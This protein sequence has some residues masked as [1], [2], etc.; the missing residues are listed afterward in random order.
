MV[1]GLILYLGEGTDFFVV[2]VD[3]A[4]YQARFAAGSR[5]DWLNSTVSKTLLLVFRPSG[6]SYAAKL[7]GLQSGFVESSMIYLRPAT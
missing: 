7:T 4:S 6:M 1:R 2:H 3:F 5:E